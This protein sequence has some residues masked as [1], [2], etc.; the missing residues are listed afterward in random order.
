MIMVTPGRRAALSRRG[1]WLAYVT[2]GYDLL[3]GF[4][5]IAAGAAVSSTALIGLGLGSFME[6]VQRGGAD[7]AVPL[8]RAGGPG[9]GP[10]P[11]SATP[12]MGGTIGSAG[13][14]TP[15]SNVHPYLPPLQGVSP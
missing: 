2:A 14:A 1:L 13:R 7:Q 12:S 15:P 4:V 9:S 8:S 10:A 5:G 3:E 6:V 11:T